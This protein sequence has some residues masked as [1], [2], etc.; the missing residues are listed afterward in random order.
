MEDI[1]LKI[2][3]IESLNDLKNKDKEINIKDEER[4]MIGITKNKIQP[5]KTIS[6]SGIKAEERILKQQTKY[7]KTKNI[8]KNVIYQDYEMRK[9]LS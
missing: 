8:E 9:L 6:L 7:K 2:A 4:N 5:N 1:M 3:L